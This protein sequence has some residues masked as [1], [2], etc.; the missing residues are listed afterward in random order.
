[1]IVADWS[2][3]YSSYLCLLGLL[4]GPSL[5]KCIVP[6]LLG[7]IGSM[8]LQLSHFGDMSL[9]KLK[10]EICHYNFVIHLSMPF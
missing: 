9:Q 1:M 3:T 2:N 8:P 5:S 10:L 6:F 4:I 7:L